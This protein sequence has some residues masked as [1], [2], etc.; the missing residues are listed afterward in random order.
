MIKG[1]EKILQFI[2]DNNAPY[3][4]L[5]LYEKGNGNTFLSRIPDDDNYSLDN[6]I[7]QLSKY[8]D[9]LEPGRYR[10]TAKK[11]FSE[12]KGFA[13]SAIEL[14][15]ETPAASQAS[16]SGIPEHVHPGAGVSI[17]GNLYLPE[18]AITDKIAA[19]LNSFK[20]EQKIERL[21]R[22]LAEAKKE[23]AIASK[24]DFGKVVSR[25]YER[26]EPLLDKIAPKKITTTASVS[27]LPNSTNMPQDKTV[28]AEQATQDLTELLQ[29]WE[30]LFPGDPL[31][32]IATIVDMAENNISKYEMAK[33]FM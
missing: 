33:T 3:W 12:A 4:T 17:G 27:G 11:K 8:F 28:T 24:D 29:K 2:R 10:I 5:S 9:L 15:G 20:T 19:A 23:L 18:T 16:V 7:E 25:I 1:K 31:K 22:E 13:E 6:S 14:L 21:E 26:V 32:I 30:N